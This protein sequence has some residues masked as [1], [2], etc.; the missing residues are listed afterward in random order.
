MQGKR[1]TT[2]FFFL[3]GTFIKLSL[4]LNFCLSAPISQLLKTG[5]VS[6]LI[7]KVRLNSPTYG[8]FFATT[9]ALALSPCC[10]NFNALDCPFIS[11]EIQSR[12]MHFLHL[13]PVLYFAPKGIQRHRDCSVR[14]SCN[15]PSQKQ[16]QR[17]QGG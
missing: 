7:P 10:I 2:K 16:G 5:P 12:N 17:L 3:Q 15:Y 4:Q 13:A 8:D 11:P 1:D 9:K 6:L 14:F